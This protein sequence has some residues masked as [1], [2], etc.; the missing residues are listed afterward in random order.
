MKQDRLDGWGAAGVAERPVGHELFYAALDLGTNNCRLLIA[1]RSAS[2]G[3][4]VVDSFA[5][6]VRLGEGLERDGMLQP[7][8]MER[9][10]AALAICARKMERWSVV[11]RR[12]VATEACRRAR[13]GPAFVARVARETGIALEIISPGEE[14]RLAARACA[15][16][17]D[18]MAASVMVLDIGGGSTEVIWL[19]QHEPKTF[20]ME[21]WTSLPIGVVSLAERFG[22]HHMDPER[23]ETMVGHVQSIL[24]E[25]GMLPERAARF[26]PERMFHLGTSGTA[27]TVAGVCLDL[28]RYERQRIDGV[29]LTRDAVDD[30]RRRLCAMTHDERAA[31][32]CVGP[33][34]ADL[35]VPGCAILEGIQRLWPSP[36]L[37]V[38][39]RGLRE[40]ILLGLMGK[41][42]GK[43]ARRRRRAARAPAYR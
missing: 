23:Y 35:V 39:D 15:S 20:R 36:R 5:R 22:R 2:G 6:I 31:H 11:Q 8:A 43:G 17:F 38:A 40:G 4:D 18:P 30:T 26:S 16:L 41:G 37:R 9:T 42:A 10:I 25:E 7:A 14:A 27:T 21:A 3:L 19:S 12:T 1:R 29:W 28:K 34:R 32:P 13:N 33:E 24:A